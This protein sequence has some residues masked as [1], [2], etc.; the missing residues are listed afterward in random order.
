M[1]RFIV[2]AVLVAGGYYLWTHMGS[3]GPEVQMDGG[4]V[5]LDTGELEVR[6]LTLGSRSESFMVFGGHNKPMKNSFSH[7][8]LAG[9]P[10]PDAQAINSRFPDFHMCKSP[11]AKQAQRLTETLQLIGADSSTRSALSEAV[12]LHDERIRK[13]GERTCVSVRGRELSIASV[14]VKE[15]AMDITSDV[16]PKFGNMPF[17]LADHAEILDCATLLH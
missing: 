4:Q 17:Y 14:H 15:Q 7:V 9:L 2:F 1:G 8:T 6:F 12:D 13:G 11:G 5:V 3:G 10:I 16:A